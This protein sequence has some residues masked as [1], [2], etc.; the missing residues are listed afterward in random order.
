MTVAI[1]F[2]AAKC[3][4]SRSN[5]GLVGCGERRETR[6]ARAE[7][8][9]AEEAEKRRREILSLVGW[10]LAYSSAHAVGIAFADPERRAASTPISPAARSRTDSASS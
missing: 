5:L 6:R 9:R 2:T 8:E 10:A 1:R 3:L 7:N 4:G